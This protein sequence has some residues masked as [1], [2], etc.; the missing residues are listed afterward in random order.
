[1]GLT[2]DDLRELLGVFEGSSWQEMTVTVG[3]DSLHVSRRAAADAGAA[4][5]MCRR[6]R[7]RS[8]RA[9]STGPA[10]SSAAP[11][12]RVDVHSAG[13]S[14]GART[15]GGVGRTRALPRCPEIRRPCSTRLRAPATGP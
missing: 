8:C 3:E 11:A 7:S 13:R 2:P 6:S 14:A 12:R 1:M 15:T 4:P 9:P 10:R 5:V